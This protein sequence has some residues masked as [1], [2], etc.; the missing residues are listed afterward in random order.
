MVTFFYIFSSSAP[1]NCWRSTISSDYQSWPITDKFDKIAFTLSADHYV[2]GVRVGSTFPERV[3][4]TVTIKI[5]HSDG[6]LIVTKTVQRRFPD[7][8][9]DPIY[10]DQAVLLSGGQQYIAA[11]LVEAPYYVSLRKYEEGE[12]TVQCSGL[13]VTFSTVSYAEFADSNGSNV[14]EGRVPALIL[15]SPWQILS[16]PLI[17]HHRVSSLPTGSQWSSIPDGWEFKIS[18]FYGRQLCFWPFRFWR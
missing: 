5:T 10:F 13:I 3:D 8:T 11:S 14:L 16:V 6:V 7:W 2:L 4:V 9:S 1:F 15:R 12:S 18:L 17:K